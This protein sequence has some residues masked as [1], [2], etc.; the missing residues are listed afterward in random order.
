M[1]LTAYALKSIIVLAMS[2]TV[3][4]SDE[5]EAEFEDLHE[6]VRQNSSLSP[7]SCNSL[8]HSWGGLGLIRSMVL[9]T[10]I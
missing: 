10:P 1:H 5:F 3:E 9:A 2:W 8:G 7:A 4:I 6:D